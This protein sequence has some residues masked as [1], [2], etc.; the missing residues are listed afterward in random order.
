MK[1]AV[2]GLWHLGLVTAASLTAV[3]HDVIGVADDAAAASRLHQA[4]LPLFEPGLQ[5]AI[6][7]GVTSGALRFTADPAAVYD[8]DVVWITFDTPVDEHDRADIDAVYD[9]IQRLFSHFGANALVLISSQLPVGSTRLLED[10]Y[11]AAYPSGTATFAFSPENLRLGQ[12][13]QSFR[14]PDRVVA[15]VRTAAD[16]ARVAQLLAPV[17]EQIEW[18]GV[19]SAEMTK[20][21]LNAWLATSVAFINEIAALCERVGADA[22]EVSRGLK[23]DARI[24][25]RAYLRPGAAFAGGTLARDLNFLE[26]LANEHAVP[27]EIAPAIRRSNT[28]HRQWQR[29]RLEEIVPS[30]DGRS[31][32][33]LGLTYKPGTSTLRRSSALELAWWLNQAGARVTAWDPAVKT[34]PQHFRESI[35][36]RPTLEE[37]LAG[38]SAAVV[39]TEW[40]ELTALQADDVVRLMAQ[41]VLL[42]ASRFLERQLGGDSRIRYL[43]VGR[44]Q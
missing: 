31:I 38:A 30:L 42:D 28:A 13:M 21:A 25:Q 14:H 19:E 10:A 43:S 32:A 16:R 9:Q 6:Q 1:I 12:A 35:E 18:M 5:E 20:H 23:S 17:T 41:P 22:G 26:H 27:I 33:L 8:A 4:D 2:V 37:A 39:M 34:L 24:G 3:G 44:G 15:G 11:R 7:V 36:L 29:R 40:P